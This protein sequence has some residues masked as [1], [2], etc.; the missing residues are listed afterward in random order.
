MFIE[1]D[2]FDKH[3]ANFENLYPQTQFKIINFDS[4]YLFNC[5]DLCTKFYNHGILNKDTLM[6]HAFNNMKSEFLN[7]AI[8]IDNSFQN[9]T[10]VDF[11]INYILKNDKDLKNGILNIL[12]KTYLGKIRIGGAHFPKHPSKIDLRHVDWSFLGGVFGGDKNAIIEF[13]QL[14]KSTCKNMII[15]K[16]TLTY[17]VNVYVLVYNQNPLL[18]DHYIA[19]H[20]LSM[21]INY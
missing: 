4:L 17:E 7:M 6:Y 14:M 20:D 21:F 10:W 13:A 12:S 15:E 19:D 5:I 2:V 16:K 3:F 11:G 18:F 9:Y 1:N 8:S